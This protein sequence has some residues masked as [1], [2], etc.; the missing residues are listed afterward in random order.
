MCVTFNQV[1]GMPTELVQSLVYFVVGDI[2]S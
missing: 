1:K 2:K